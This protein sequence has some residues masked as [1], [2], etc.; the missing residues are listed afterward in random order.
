MTGFRAPIPTRYAFAFVLAAAVAVTAAV[1]ARAKVFSP[2]TFTLENG[3]Q[4][5][6]ISNRREPI[7]THMMWYRVGSADDPPG[8]SGIAHFLEHLMFKGTETLAP[9]EFS[10]IVA[11]NGGR[12]NAFTSYDYTG[13][14]QNVAV[15]RLETVMRIEA[16]RM[17]N[18]VLTEEIVAPEREVV[19]EERLSRTD[20]N[21][22]SILGEASRAS[23]YQ[24]HPYGNP[25]IGWAHEIAK[26]TAR[27]AI[28]FYRRHYAPNNAILVIAGDVNAAQIRPLAEKY[29]GAI[30]RR[31]LPPRTRPRE[32]EH[33]A[34]L[35]IELRDRRVRQPSWSRSYLAPVYGSEGS[36]HA[37]ALQV[38]SQIVGSG[39]SSRL[40]QA[41]VVKGKLATSA[42]A[43]YDS[44][45][46][47]RSSFS[48]YASP[49]PGV[50]LDKIE[51]AMETEIAKL[52]AGGV[53]EE[54]VERAKQRLRRAAIFARDSLST[55]ARIIGMALTTGRTVDDVEAWPDRIG[56]V[57]VDQVN[58]AAKAVLR[59]QSS[60]TAQL[61]PEEPEVPE[62]KVSQ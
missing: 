37:Y 23:F 19:L 42:G 3:L 2:E 13:Y 50:T 48:V 40:H 49:R 56:A 28:D 16:D 36:E 39:A 52:L 38:L 26:L 59:L 30:A 53:E 21:P 6:V 11:A 5:V 31:D 17:T 46:L 25:I 51:A 14:Y 41:L 1:P 54:E 55:G 7:V 60:I 45:R 57:T 9:G 18:L 62:E 32:P 33:R 29:Y 15:D 44:L 8:R 10:K 47:D 34:A 27:D 24:N 4:V 22:G 35:R 43:D 12:E 20:N 61:L 58:A